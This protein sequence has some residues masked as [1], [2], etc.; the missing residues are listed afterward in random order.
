MKRGFRRCALRFLEKLAVMA[1]ARLLFSL[2]YFP[3]AH[4]ANI[5]DV[6]IVIV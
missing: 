4:A 6:N 2:V 3:K 1:P 5:N